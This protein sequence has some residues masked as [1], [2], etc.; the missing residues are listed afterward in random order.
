MRTEEFINA[1]KWYADSTLVDVNDFRIATKIHRNNGKPWVALLHGFPTCSY[2]WYK[3]WPL[4]SKSYQLICFDFLG[5]GRSDKPYPHNYSIEEQARLTEIL[6]HQYE[7]TDV[8]LVAH[9]YAVS[10]AQEMIANVENSSSALK[11]TSVAFLNGGLFS[12]THRPRLIQKLLIGPFGKLVNGL[13]TKSTL[14]KNLDRIMGARTRLTSEE[15]TELW[16]LINYNKGKRVFHLLIR[17]MND[18]KRNRDRWVQAMQKTDIPMR[19]INGPEDPISGR[20]LTVRY[21]E[22]IPDAD[23][24]ILEGIGHYPNLEAPGA[25]VEHLLSLFR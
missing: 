16:E 23:I 15:L 18:R 6:L 2:D 24:A 1:E 22:L 5:F 3:M 9:N 19:L 11:I 20:H 25:V 4:L 13:V 8:H 14:K 21:R 17:Y 12:E 7:I 10:V